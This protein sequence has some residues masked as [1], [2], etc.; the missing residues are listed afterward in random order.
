MSTFPKQHTLASIRFFQI[1]TRTIRNHDNHVVSTH[2]NIIQHPTSVTLDH[3]S[4]L[5]LL[6]PAFQTKTAPVRPARRLIE[7]NARGFQF[8]GLGAHL[9]A[10]EEQPGE[11]ERRRGHEDG[12]G[13]AFEANGGRRWIRGEHGFWKVVES[14][15]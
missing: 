8:Q 12:G 15:V 11:D 9:V 4:S 1:S 13:F 6:I 10:R 14:Q 3:Q 5:S 2:T 7:V